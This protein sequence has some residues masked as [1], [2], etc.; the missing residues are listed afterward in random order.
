MALVTFITYLYSF[1][2]SFVS[3][4]PPIP[5]ITYRYYVF[6]LLPAYCYS[7]RPRRREVLYI[8]TYIHTKKNETVDPRKK[9]ILSRLFFR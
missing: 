8:R 2:S 1:C 9:P 4:M 5:H 3:A 7:I 6:L